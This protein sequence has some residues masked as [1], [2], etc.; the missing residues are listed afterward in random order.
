MQEE[1]VNLYLVAMHY[2]PTDM[3]SASTPVQIEGSGNCLPQTISYLLSK[4]QEMYTEIRVRIVYEAVRNIDKYLDH[5]YISKG[6]HHFYEHGTLPDQYAQ[7]SD[8]YNPHGTFNMVR[9]P[10]VIEDLHRTVYCIDDR[11]NQH[12]ALNIMWA[13]MQVKAGQ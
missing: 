13:P 11:Y 12:P 3:P 1:T 4:S 5:I 8:N 9:N 2:M 6:A 10:N 7:Y